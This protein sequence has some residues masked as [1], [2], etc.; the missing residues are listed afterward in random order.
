VEPGVTV[1]VAAHPARLRN[2][3]LARALSSIWSQTRQPERVLIVNDTD[4]EGA[5]A[6]RQ[7]LLGMVQTRWTA[8]LDSDD[9]WY[10][11][12]LEKLLQVA[13]QTGAVWVHPYFD[14]E[15][16]PF[17]SAEAPQGH[18]GLPYNPCTPHHTTMCV[19]EDTALAREV[20]FPPSADRGSCSN[21]DWAHITEF[22][23]LCCERGLSMVHLAERTFKYHM[24]HGNSSGLP[25]QG[26][27]L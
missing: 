23:R 27:A 22:A 6:T 9:E 7:R 20:G 21:E 16:D 25:G 24:G 14:S 8:W 2:G 3:L 19:L 15:S 17:A 5:G 18:F 4:R 12:H 1:C 13:E 26:D 11:E 10:P